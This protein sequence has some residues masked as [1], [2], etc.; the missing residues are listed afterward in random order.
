[1][2]LFPCPRTFVCLHNLHKSYIMLQRISFHIVYVC[3][4]SLP[5]ICRKVENIKDSLA[6]S[7]SV[8]FSYPPLRYTDLVPKTTTCVSG[9][10]ERANSVI[11]S[12]HFTCFLRPIF[13]FSSANQILKHVLQGKNKETKKKLW[14]EREKFN[15]LF[16]SFLIF[17]SLLFLFRLISLGLCTVFVSVTNLIVTCKQFAERRDASR[18]VIRPHIQHSA[19]LP[20]FPR[21]E[22]E[23]HGTVSACICWFLFA[24]WVCADM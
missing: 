1:M 24:L 4:F 17:V 18:Q 13:F 12:T 19:P 11:T 2:P 16:H 7:P 20:P 9:F 3:Q 21:P 8:D 15:I 14:T 10:S 23:T 22:C 5:P 6:P